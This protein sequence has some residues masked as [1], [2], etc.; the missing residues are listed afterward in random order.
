MISLFLSAC[1]AK[2][3]K[4]K[5]TQA[6]SNR[7]SVPLF[8]FSFFFVPGKH[9]F[10]SVKDIVLSSSEGVVKFHCFLCRHV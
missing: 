1:M 3:K 2:K 6:P 4:R 5:K 7:L 8:S 9:P 10:F